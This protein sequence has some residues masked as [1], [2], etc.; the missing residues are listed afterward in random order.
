MAIPAKVAPVQTGALI[1]GVLCGTAA[2]T[3]GLS[4]GDVI[5]SVNG[6]AVTS[7]A[8][9]TKLMVQYRPGQQIAVIWVDPSGHKHTSDMKLTAHPPY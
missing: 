6:Q 1:D 3:A 2:S 8:S 4:G 5:T 9:L 7:P